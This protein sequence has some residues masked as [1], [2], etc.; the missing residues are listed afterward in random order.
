MVDQDLFSPCDDL[1]HNVVVFRDFAAVIEIGEPLQRL[2]G[3]FEAVGFI[4]AVEL[5][6]RSSGDIQSGMGRKEPIQVGLVSLR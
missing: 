2:V 3:G 6:E 5:L 4:D 1:I